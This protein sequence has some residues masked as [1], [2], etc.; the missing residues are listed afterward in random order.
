MGARFSA[1]VVP[2]HY[3][4][5]DLM[6]HLV[7]YDSPLPEGLRSYLLAYLWLE[8]DRNIQ[9]KQQKHQALL[10][11]LISTMGDDSSCLHQLLNY[12]IISQE[13]RE[14]LMA[15]ATQMRPRVPSTPKPAGLY[16]RR[17]Y[18]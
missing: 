4:W 13:H 18:R 9:D 2:L 11:T 7:F 12:D 16:A 15:F 17:K 14:R 6:K 10:Q 5:S 1:K 3:S 8:S